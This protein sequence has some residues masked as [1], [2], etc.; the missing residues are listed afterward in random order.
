[1]TRPDGLEETLFGSQTTER[2]VGFRSETNGT[3]EGEGNK[4]TS[5]TTFGIDFTNVQLDGSV[6]LG[7]DK[8]VGSRA[9]YMRDS[10][11]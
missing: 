9:N 5:V 1:L 4:F 8:A 11:V 6:I 10:L 2:V 3:G 7:G